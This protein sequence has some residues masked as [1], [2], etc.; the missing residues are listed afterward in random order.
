MS[1]I[2]QDPQFS[3]RVRDS[4]ALQAVMATI[5]AKMINVEVGQVQIHL[6]F[7]ADLS[8]QHGYLHAGIITTIV[9]SACGYAAYSLMPAESNVLTVEFK[10]N[11]LAPAKGEYFIA[12]GQV[13]KAGR[14]L[15]VSEG[16]VLAYE[17]GESKLIA[18][19]QATLMAL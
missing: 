11:F 2:A 14:T 10:V 12:T 8:Q 15:T 1:L 19:M 16:R 7:R 5:G 4:F 3:Q 17:N 9:D 18:A 6:P 13:L